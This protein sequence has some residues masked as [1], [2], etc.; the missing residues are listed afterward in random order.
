MIVHNFNWSRFFCISDGVGYVWIFSS[1]H[2]LWGIIPPTLQGGENLHLPSC[3]A[4]IPPPET[5]A[6]VKGIEVDRPEEAASS[7]PKKAAKE[8]D[9][10]KSKFKWE[11]RTLLMDKDELT[12]PKF[13][14]CNFMGSMSR[15]TS[16]LNGGFSRGKDL[17]IP[18]RPTI[19]V[20][21]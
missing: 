11:S 7:D 13:F 20:V 6:F 2:D 12:W 10:K 21:M 18:W 9:K 14:G 17:Q 19:E 1:K 5:E 4:W 3:L 15:V 16:C 8:K